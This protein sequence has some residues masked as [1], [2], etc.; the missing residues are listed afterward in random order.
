[1]FTFTLPSLLTVQLH[2]LSENGC[3]A[4]SSMSDPPILLYI[5]KQMDQGIVRPIFSNLQLQRVF[6]IEDIKNECGKAKYRNYY[7]KSEN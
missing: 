2:S 1:M 6:G 7:R 5:K 3:L 4:S